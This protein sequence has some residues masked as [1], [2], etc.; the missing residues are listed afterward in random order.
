[1]IMR[2]GMKMRIGKEKG[3]KGGGG[4]EREYEREIDRDRERDDLSLMLS[5]TFAQDSFSGYPAM[6]GEVS[7]SRPPVESRPPV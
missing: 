5:S 1:M 6:H 4:R 3:E 2:I 7:L